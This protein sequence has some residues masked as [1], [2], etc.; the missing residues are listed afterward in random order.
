[1]TLRGVSCAREGREGTDVMTSSSSFALTIARAFSAIGAASTAYTLRAPARAAKRDR[2]PVPQ[3]TSRTTA[4]RK[5][6][7]L[8]RMKPP[9]V[10]VRTP[11]CS[12]IWW[13]SASP[14]D[15]K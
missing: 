11:S 6:A 14:Y 15:S 8:R 12:M 10:A 5:T 4:P 1:M 3:P 13:I 9:Y 7:G 2:M